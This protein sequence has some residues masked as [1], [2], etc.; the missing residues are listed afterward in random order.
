VSGNYNYATIPVTNQ[1][2]ITTNYRV[3]RTRNYLNGNI[4]IVVS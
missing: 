4:S 3:Y 1:F 2:G